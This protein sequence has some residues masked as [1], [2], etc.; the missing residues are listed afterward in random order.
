MTVRPQRPDVGDQPVLFVD[1]VDIDGL[2]SDPLDG[3]LLIAKPGAT[4]SIQ[5]PFSQFVVAPDGQTGRVEYT[6]DPLDTP[7]TWRVWWAFTAGVIAAEGYQ[8]A[9]NPRN[10]PDPA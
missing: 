4:T 5:V 9:V 6:M 1:V 8:F 10:V 7:G 3:E 2:A